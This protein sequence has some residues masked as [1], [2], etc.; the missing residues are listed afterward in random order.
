[1][2]VGTDLVPAFQMP[3]SSPST[4]FIIYHARKKIT[5]VKIQ[6]T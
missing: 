2:L 1:M 6:L 5:L 4:Y 3:H